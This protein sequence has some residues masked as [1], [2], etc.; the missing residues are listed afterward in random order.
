MLP[1]RWTEHAVMQLERIRAL[2]APPYRVFYR[3][4]RDCIEVLAIVHGRQLL[5]DAF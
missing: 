4:R 2:V 5:A 1:L 3:A